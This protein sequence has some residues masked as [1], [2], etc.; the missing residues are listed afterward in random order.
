MRVTITVTYAPKFI[1]Q[2]DCGFC[3]RISHPHIHVSPAWQLFLPLPTPVISSAPPQASFL[4]PPRR[5]GGGGGEAAAESPLLQQAWVG[6]RSSSSSPPLAPP[7][8]DATGPFSSLLPSCENSFG[9]QG[10]GGHR[11]L[12]QL[13]LVVLPQE[14]VKWGK[15]PIRGLNSLVVRSA[16]HHCKTGTRPRQN[17][18]TCEKVEGV[19]NTCQIVHQ[20]TQC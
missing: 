12:Y 18:A 20:I 16:S 6:G 1:G 14:V 4:L 19:G 11:T 2:G 9:L 7:R 8:P 5:G 13:W 3:W 10:R 15:Q 17:H